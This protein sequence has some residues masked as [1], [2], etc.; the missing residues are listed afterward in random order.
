MIYK[1]AF[2][3]YQKVGGGGEGMAPLTTPLYPLPVCDPVYLFILFL[4]CL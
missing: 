3:L 1:K 2:L 4:F